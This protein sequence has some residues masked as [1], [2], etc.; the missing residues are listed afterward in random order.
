MDEIKFSTGQA[1]MVPATI[2]AAVVQDGKVYYEVDVLG[3]RVP[4]ENIETSATAVSAAAMRQ[5]EEN[6]RARWM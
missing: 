1:V 2:R 5:L 3:W 6:I 4:Q